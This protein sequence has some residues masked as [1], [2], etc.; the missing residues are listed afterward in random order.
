MLT[1]FCDCVLQSRTSTDTPRSP[2]LDKGVG[3]P[4]VVALTAESVLDGESRFS[5]FWNTAGVFGSQLRTQHWHQLMALCVISS[6]G[7]NAQ[8]PQVRVPVI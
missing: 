7:T 1:C 2:Q 8:T 3:L 5:T 4:N 6:H